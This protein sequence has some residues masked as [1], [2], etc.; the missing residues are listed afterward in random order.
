MSKNIYKSRSSET[1]VENFVK[2]AA[3]Y[4]EALDRNDS[5]SANKAHDVVSLVYKEI[6]NRGPEQIRLLRPL[7]ASD[8]PWIRSAAATYLLRVDEKIAV[9]VLDEISKAPRALGMMA[10]TILQ[11]WRSGKLEL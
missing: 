7:L 3:L 11:L 8:N 1:L 2:A 5:R 6:S 9:S 4:G 10:I